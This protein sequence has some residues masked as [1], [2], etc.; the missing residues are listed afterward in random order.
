VRG[1]D[2]TDFFLAGAVGHPVQAPRDFRA[3]IG[4]FK[5]PLQVEMDVLQNDVLIKHTFILSRV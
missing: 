3:L 1:I 4:L 5:Y 2:A